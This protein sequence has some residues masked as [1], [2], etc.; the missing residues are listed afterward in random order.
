MIILRNKNYSG[1]DLL[2]AG[3]LM[4]VPIIAIGGGDL[5]SE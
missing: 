4:S 2:K 5:V 3:M 1:E